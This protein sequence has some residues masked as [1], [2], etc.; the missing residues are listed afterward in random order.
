MTNVQRP[1][2]LKVWTLKPHPQSG[3][4]KNLTLIS[5]L[6]QTVMEGKDGSEH[7]E[8]NDGQTNVQPALFIGALK[9]TDFIGHRECHPAQQRLRRVRVVPLTRLVLGGCSNPPDHILIPPT[10]R[11]SVDF[12]H[13]RTRGFVMAWI[14]CTNFFRIRR[15]TLDFPDHL[16]SSDGG[17][18]D[19]TGG[20]DV[21]DPNTFEQASGDPPPADWM[22]RINTRVSVASSVH[23]VLGT[24]SVNAFLFF[25]NITERGPSLKVCDAYAPDLWEVNLAEIKSWRCRAYALHATQQP[26]SLTLAPDMKTLVMTLHMRGIAKMALT[27]QGCEVCG[28]PHFHQQPEMLLHRFDGIVGDPYIYVMNPRGCAFDIFG[29]LVYFVDASDGFV[30]WTKL[31]PGAD[32]I[33]PAELLWNPQNRARR[34]PRSVS[35][36]SHLDALVVSDWTGQQIHALTRDPDLYKLNLNSLITTQ[37][38]PFDLDASVAVDKVFWSEPAQNRLCRAVWGASLEDNVTEG[39]TTWLYGKTIAGVVYSSYF[40]RVFMAS[41]RAGEIL[42]I[43][44]SDPDD[45]PIVHFSSRHS[46]VTEVRYALRPLWLAVDD[47][48]GSL[49]FSVLSAPNVSAYSLTDPELYVKQEEGMWYRPPEKNLTYTDS[50]Y[51]LA[52]TIWLMKKRPFSTSLLY[53]PQPFYTNPDCT[54]ITITRNDDWLVFVEM[55]LDVNANFS[56]RIG[57]LP[58]LSTTDE[59][60]SLNWRVRTRADVH[61][62]LDWTTAIPNVVFAPIGVAN[63]WGTMED[64]ENNSRVSAAVFGWVALVLLATNVLCASTYNLFIPKAL[65]KDLIDKSS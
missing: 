12:M 11:L 35:R 27:P 56:A 65:C 49:Y 62:L 57:R 37:G 34:A 59:T 9:P 4:T 55:P 7:G 2:Q 1:R 31:W 15:L 64:N 63:L 51:N 58:L 26:T 5:F 25:S 44:H 19:W 13:D 48:F 20:L 46:R 52:S 6:A 47:N 29:D 42:S 10:E 33:Y 41:P 53:P 24:E 17:A 22:T 50:G 39:A 30:R 45:A 38:N 60:F 32:A 23:T 18:T 21:S 36:S 8:V 40:D 3:L 61:P 54:I 43:S 14:V 16:W 28:N